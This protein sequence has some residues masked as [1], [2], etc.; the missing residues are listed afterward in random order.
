MSTLKQNLCLPVLGVAGAEAAGGTQ[1][2][3]PIECWL[4]RHGASYCDEVFVMPPDL[5]TAGPCYHGE[6]LGEQ[7]PSPGP[8]GPSA[9]WEAGSVKEGVRWAGP[10]V[11]HGVEDAGLRARTDMH[12]LG[13]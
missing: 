3:I 6:V 12:D 10:A 8:R 13:V 11:Q 1:H 7:A 4:E 9:H 5:L 2:M